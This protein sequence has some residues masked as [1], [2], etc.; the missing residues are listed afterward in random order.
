METEPVTLAH[1]ALP[2]GTEILADAGYLWQDYSEHGCHE[3]Q[4]TDALVGILKRH[5]RGVVWDI[6]SFYGYFSVVASTVVD[7]SLVHVF[8]PDP[9]SASIVSANS[10]RYTDGA[11]TVNNVALGAPGSDTPTGD[12]YRRTNAGV[13]PTVLKIDVDGAET[14]VMG[15]LQQTVAECQPFILLEVHIGDAYDVSLPRLRETLAKQGYRYAY[16]PEHR[17]M[18]GEWRGFSVSRGLPNSTQIGSDYMILGVPERR[19][20]DLA[21]LL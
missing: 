4:T 16:C 11:I 7:P 20:P 5:E 8:E 17:A 15:G 14:A 21:D 1:P 6:G 2:E 10:D 18:D 19:N 13:D 3:P 12:G 9:E